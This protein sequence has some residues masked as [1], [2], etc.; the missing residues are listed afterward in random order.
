VATIMRAKI[1]IKKHIK[2]RFLVPIQQNRISN[3]RAFIL[4]D[5]R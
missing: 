1:L 5:V 3:Q 2:F 4:T